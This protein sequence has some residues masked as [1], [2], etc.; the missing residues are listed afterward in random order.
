MTF[1]VLGVLVVLV[2]APGANRARAE[3]GAWLRPTTDPGYRFVYVG[4]RGSL[5]T[6]V[7]DRGE[8]VGSYGERAF[9]WRQGRTR[10][11][12][13]LG[14]SGG[15]ATGINN[16][17]QVVGY[18]RTPDMRMHAVLW[19]GT[20]IRSLG[21]AEAT[22]TAIN[23]HGVIVGMTYPARGAPYAW[24]W[25]AGRLT[26][27]TGYGVHRSSFTYVYDINSAGQIVG[28][29]DAGGWVLDGTRL[30]RLRSLSTTPTT[31]RAINDRG[32]VAGG[33][34]DRGQAHRARIWTHGRIRSLG[35]MPPPMPMA[36][37]PTT[38]ARG[39][40]DSGDV[41]GEHWW[42][43]IPVQVLPFLWHDGRMT[44]LPTPSVRPNGAAAAVNEHGLIVGYV[45]GTDDS[46]A[47]AWLPSP[48][49]SP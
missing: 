20:G 24:R 48:R 1:G 21:T 2:A 13:T 39:I 8:V 25:S 6:D 33:E 42:Y 9:V 23:D 45:Q 7:N 46:F 47:A 49:T 34:A 5:A 10:Y 35:T 4:S 18:S 12:R 19:S 22:A 3:P 17:G 27:L 32:V 14:G 31:A 44:R 16:R 37:N 11:L 40:N 41:V 36:R 29:D 15:M 38:M 43:G 26:P 30:T 28:V